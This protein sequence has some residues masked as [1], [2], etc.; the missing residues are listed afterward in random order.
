MKIFSSKNG[1]TLGPIALA[2]TLIATSAMG[3]SVGA[4]ADTDQHI[5][6]GGKMPPKLTFAQAWAENFGQSTP[7]SENPFDS[8]NSTSNQ[9]VLGGDFQTVLGLCQSEAEVGC[10]DPIQFSLDGGTTWKSAIP[11]QS[12]GQRFFKFGGYISANNWDLAFTST[13][14]ANP[15]QGLLRAVPPNYWQLPGAENAAGDTYMINAVASS[16]L[17]AGKA[18]LKGL[19]LIATAGKATMTSNVANC[20]YWNVQTSGIKVDDPT[21]PGYC[22]EPV[23]LPTNLRLRVSVQLGNRLGELKGWFDGRINDPNIDFGTATPGVITVEGSPMAVDYTETVDIPKGDPLYGGSAN[24]EEGQIAFGTRGIEQP[25]TGLALYKQYLSKIPDAAA[26]QNTVWR[27]SSWNDS[28]MASNRCSSTP[29]V[30]GIVISNATTYDPAP[31]TLNAQDGSLNFTVAA[32]H[33]N[34]DGTPNQ[35]IYR[36]FVQKALAKCLWGSDVNGSATI[37]VTDGDGTQDAAITTMGESNSWVHFS[38]T[39]FHYSVPTVS[40]S[41]PKA[42]ASTSITSTETLNP[43]MSSCAKYLGKKVVKKIAVK[44]GAKC[45]TGYRKLG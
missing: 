16:A 40:V 31:P 23:N 27:I 33:L 41:F 35:G 24:T 25:R 32:P 8:R 11:L 12:P 42:S 26:A 19:D 44:A 37:S 3:T 22:F 9:M 1:R 30:Q 14:D 2:V 6:S 4:R 28:A 29:G 20:P 21:H 38:A 13:Y 39:G 36:L 7:M 15:S 18:S 10:I 17:L 45:P 34:P 43:K 5:W